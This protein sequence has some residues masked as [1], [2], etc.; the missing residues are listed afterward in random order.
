MSLITID[1]F[2]DNISANLAKGILEAE[3]IPCYLKNDSIIGIRPELSV[4]FSGISL[5]VKEEDAK[6]AK[7]I[8]EMTA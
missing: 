8:L 5:Q 2:P 1:N 7:E 4:A 6:K 3:G